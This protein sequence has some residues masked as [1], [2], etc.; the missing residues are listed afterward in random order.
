MQLL[1]TSE[2]LENTGPCQILFSA[3]AAGWKVGFYSCFQVCLS[4]NDMEV[5]VTKE[6]ETAKNQ[7][8]LG[9]YHH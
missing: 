9:S 7:E 6:I 5:D 1:K 8:S 2:A 3:S 4:F